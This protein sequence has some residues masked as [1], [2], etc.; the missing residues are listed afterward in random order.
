MKSAKLSHPVLELSPRITQRLNLYALAAGAAGVSV[1]AWAQPSEAEVVLTGVDVNLG[2]NSYYPIDIDHD[3]ALDFSISNTFIGN[4]SGYFRN[5]FRISGGAE[6]QILTSDSADY[7]AAL[8][9]GNEI[10]PGAKWI[11]KSVLLESTWGISSGVYDFGNWLHKKDRY[12]GLRFEIDG[13]IHYGWARLSV[14]NNS[15][16]IMRVHV[17]GYAY[18]T[19]A[20]QPIRAGQTQ[21][22]AES[23]E[24]AI[25]ALTAPANSVGQLALGAAAR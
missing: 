14:R 9:S 3:G 22:D 7:A 23:I 13:A 6:G 18:E 4:P 2:H 25:T 19:V 20:D 17:S 10:G 12:L 5:R 1:L 21:D 11:A 16:G 24:T 15:A 8:R